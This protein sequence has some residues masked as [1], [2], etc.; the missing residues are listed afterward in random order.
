MGQPVK[1]KKGRSEVILH[2]P[3]EAQRRILNEGWKY[4]NSTPEVKEEVK[5]PKTD[6]DNKKDSG[7]SK[8]PDP[9]S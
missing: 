1:I 5:E 3:I 9:K 8:D 7:E 6:G 2:D 4:V